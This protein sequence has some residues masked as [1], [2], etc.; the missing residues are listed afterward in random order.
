[1]DYMYVLNLAKHGAW[2]AEL[3]SPTKFQLFLLVGPIAE[4]VSFVV[5]V[6]FFHISVSVQ[7]VALQNFCS[8]PCKKVEH[9]TV[10]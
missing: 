5:V 4:G 8:R 3:A 10:L 1:M 6:F 9:A 7:T 2:T